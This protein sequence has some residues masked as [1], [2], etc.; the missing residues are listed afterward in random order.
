MVCRHKVK[1]IGVDPSAPRAR[2]GASECVTS[3][4]VSRSSKQQ[5]EQQQQPRKQ[6]RHEHGA[7]AVLKPCRRR[8]VI[9][10]RRRASVLNLVPYLPDPHFFTRTNTYP[11]KPRRDQGHSR[12]SGLACSLFGDKEST[13]EGKLHFH[14]CTAPANFT[15]PILLPRTRGKLPSP[16]QGR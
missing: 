1:M 10:R 16:V 2:M 5:Q 12:H 8:S 4:S 7:P 11:G 14:T 6:E 13:I 15:M 9:S 3:P